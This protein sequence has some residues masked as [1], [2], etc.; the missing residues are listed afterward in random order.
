MVAVAINHVFTIIPIYK[1][2][3]TLM[4]V[5]RSVCH[6]APAPKNASAPSCRMGREGGWHN[7]Q[8]TGSPAASTRGRGVFEHF[9]LS[10]GSPRHHEASLAAEVQF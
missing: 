6:H 8:D 2:Q 7:R 10:Q 3:E 5:C 1:I 4:S 9:W